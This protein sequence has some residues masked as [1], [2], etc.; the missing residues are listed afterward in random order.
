MLRRRTRLLV[1]ITGLI[2]GVA[3]VSPA[4]AGTGIGA[5]FNLGRS[6]TVNRTTTL[7]GTTSGRI[8]ALANK[9]TGSALSLST[10]V[11]QA[12]MTVTSS[13]RVT[14]LNA[15]LLDGLDASA[16]VKGTG[17]LVS[18]RTTMVPVTILTPILEIA[19]FG[20]VQAG[21]GWSGFSNYSIWF[22]NGPDKATD[23]WVTYSPSS[24]AAFHALAPGGGTY[25]SVLME[26]ASEVYRVT[27]GSPDG[28]M[29]E[30][31][32]AGVLDGENCLLYAS[33]FGG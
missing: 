1:A 21:C 17:S 11:G 33:A 31:T 6:N 29:S 30:L 5:L 28:R 27:L 13:T 24:I 23:L 9:G 3:M 26:E 20:E 4:A 12:P 22:Q 16:F 2:A 32:V 18:S 25:I 7:T 10:R 8:L 19:G 14:H 15:D